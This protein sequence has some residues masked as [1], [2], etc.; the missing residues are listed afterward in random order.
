MTTSGAGA[1][2]STR[3]LAVL[4][5]QGVFVGYAS[6]FNRRDQAGD[7]VMPGAFTDSLKKRGAQGIRML[8]QHD[9]AEPVGAWIDIAENDRGL[10]VRGRLNREVQRGR[11]LAALLAEHGLDGLSIGFKTVSA[12]R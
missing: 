4:D 7:I 2:R 12:R 11:E 3:P 1:P 9:P 10:H 8:F 5:A 6:L